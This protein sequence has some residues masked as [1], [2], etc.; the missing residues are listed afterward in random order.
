MGV[1]KVG[2]KAAST[3][4]RVG[5]QDYVCRHFRPLHDCAHRDE[6]GAR[7]GAAEF[8]HHFVHAFHVGPGGAKAKAGMPGSVDGDGAMQ[9]VRRRETAGGPI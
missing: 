3:E 8:L 7:L 5:Q 1:K 2:G 9:E 4:H 6:H